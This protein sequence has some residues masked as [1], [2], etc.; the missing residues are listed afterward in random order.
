MTAK[1]PESHAR[2]GRSLG[3]PHGAVRKKDLRAMACGADAG[4]GMHS[5]PHIAAVGQAR[6]ARM[7]ADPNPDADA[8]WPPSRADAPL[9]PQR[10]IDG[11]RGRVKTANIS[12]GIS[13]QLTLPFIG[14]F[15]TYWRISSVVIIS[16]VN[17]SNE[18]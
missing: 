14:S 2:R 4:R 16:R 8:T 7:D 18:P 17:E 3:G 1:S 13:A 11:P 15:E 10:R 6:P 12:S 9:D 5:Q